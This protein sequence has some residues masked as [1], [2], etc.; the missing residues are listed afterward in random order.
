[1]SLKLFLMESTKSSNTTKVILQQFLDNL[2]DGH[3]SYDESVVKVNIGNIIKKHK[4]SNLYLVIYADKTPNLEVK[5]GKSKNKEDEYAIV[6]F[7]PGKMPTRKNI[8]GFI[9][10]N[11]SVYDGIMDALREYLSNGVFSDNEYSSNYEKVKY[12]NN[13]DKF[14]E[15]Y[16][17]L[18][19]L[20]DSDINDY[21]V[22]SE[23]LMRK[24]N[25]TSNQSERQKFKMAIKELQKDMLGDGFDG[26]M[27]K[28]KSKFSEC[29]NIKHLNA[30]YK[31]KLDSR[32]ESYF[33]QNISP[34][35]K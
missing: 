9:S 10:R 24:Y 29:G 1:M 4:F 15:M 35:M 22:M 11:D 27:K 28:A 12:H 7:K 25:S 30:A 16:N 5:F 19:K 3:L 31:K 33:E 23:K 32:M 8:D 18:S 17:K 21:K 13:D 2:D 34:F 14:E 20:L 6:V 26:F